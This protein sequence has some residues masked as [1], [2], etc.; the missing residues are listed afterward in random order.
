MADA[1]TPD[2]QVLADPAVMAALR[3]AIKEWTEDADGCSC[4]DPEACHAAGHE[5]AMAHPR[6]FFEWLK[7]LADPPDMGEQRSLS[8]DRRA[9][10]ARKH[11]EQLRA[12]RLA[13]A[14]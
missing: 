3:L 7:L 4:R 9:R 2:L 8:E 14:S 5:G 1:P 10:W 12:E 13:A 6:E 11:R